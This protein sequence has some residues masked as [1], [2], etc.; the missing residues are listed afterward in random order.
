MNESFIK[1]RLIQEGIL[2]TDQLGILVYQQQPNEE[3]L[4]GN[5]LR[6]QDQDKVVLLFIIQCSAVQC[7][8]K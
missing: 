1:F 4:Q 8:V 5:W 7:S 3:D 6:A 2:S